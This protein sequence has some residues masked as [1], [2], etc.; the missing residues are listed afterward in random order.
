MLKHALSVV[1]ALVIVSGVSFAAP[2]NRGGV[3]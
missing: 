1:T 2:V 3:L